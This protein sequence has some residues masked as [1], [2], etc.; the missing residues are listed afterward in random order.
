MLVKKTI[1]NTM[2]IFFY[3]ALEPIYLTEP[4]KMNTI[5]LPKTDIY[6]KP[7]KSAFYATFKSAHSS[8][9]CRYFN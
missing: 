6:Q 2:S 5:D 8:S 9:L 3:L 1:K 4:K 7:D